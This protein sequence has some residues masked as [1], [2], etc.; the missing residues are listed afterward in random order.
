MNPPAICFYIHWRSNSLPGRCM[1]IK[2]IN[3][4]YENLCWKPNHDI[5]LVFD[6]RAC[7]STRNNIIFH[8]SPSRFIVWTLA[9]WFARNHTL[10]TLKVTYWDD[11]ASMVLVNYKLYLHFMEKFL[12]CHFL[13]SISFALF[14][15]E[16]THLNL[17]RFKGWYLFAHWQSR[18]GSECRI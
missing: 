9:L 15:T 11:S 3:W 2:S 4:Y 18:W 10:Y 6:F 12:N 17:T 1:R 14:V 5:V 8:K 13:T 7:Q 16:K